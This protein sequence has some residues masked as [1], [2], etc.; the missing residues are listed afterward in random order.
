MAS[1]TRRKETVMSS[2]QTQPPASEKPRVRI[3][4]P[5][6]RTAHPRLHKTLVWIGVLAV[7]AFPLP[8]W[9]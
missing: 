1:P 4:P 7:A 5:R 3:V 6:L 9:W 8:W 2:S